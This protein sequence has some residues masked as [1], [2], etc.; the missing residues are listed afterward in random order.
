MQQDFID[1]S[2]PAS[3]VFTHIDLADHADGDWQRYSELDTVL[4]T[5]N[6]SIAS[7]SATD[8]FDRFGN[9][10]QSLAFSEKN[11]SGSVTD[12]TPTM[13][14][15]ISAFLWFGHLPKHGVDHRALN[16]AERL[17][18]KLV[19]IEIQADRVPREWWFTG[20]AECYRKS[21]DNVAAQKAIHSYHEALEFAESPS[22]NW[23]VRVSAL[24]DHAQLFESEGRL[25]EAEQK[26]KVAISL[27]ETNEDLSTT[28][29]ERLR[30]YN[31]QAK[32]ESG[33]CGDLWTCAYLKRLA[34]LYKKAGRPEEKAVRQKVQELH[35]QIGLSQVLSMPEAVSII[36]LGPLIATSHVERDLMSV[37][38][39]I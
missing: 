4:A 26:L 19:D 9:S 22:N 6:K 23:R 12:P 20:L 15:D 38:W 30:R 5:S 13:I 34:D 33:Y 8:G 35:K 27:C 14:Q 25:V 18:R 31:V 28:G 21:G 36:A 37:L 17:Y 3:G 29:L 10:V 24:T 1:G 32:E 2:L 16:Y 39:D 11:K 7:L